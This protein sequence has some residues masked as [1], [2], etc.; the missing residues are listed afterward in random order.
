MSKPECQIC[1]RELPDTAYVCKPCT[2]RLDRILGEVT[3]LV[4]EVETT[5]L[6]QARTGSA[7]GVVNHK[8]D[9]DNLP[10]EAPAQA[11]R[12]L[13][14]LFR[15]L[16]SK[17]SSIRGVTRPVDDPSRQSGWLLNHTEWL[18]HREDGADIQRELE[19]AIHNLR[20][21][22]DLPPERVF[23][24]PCGAV[25]YTCTLIHD[26]EQEDCDE[27]PIPG[28]QPC[29]G[30][31]YGTPTS[32]TVR[33]NSCGSVQPMDDRREWLLKAVEDQLDYAARL[34]RAL[35]RLGMEVTGEAIRKWAE[36]GRLTAHSH[37]EN[38]RPLYRVGDVLD[39]LAL[40][41][42]RQSRKAAA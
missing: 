12:E 42:Q 28:S 34:S 33:C 31:L 13:R 23:A 19:W 4:G 6:R 40:E 32:K 35:S 22:I 36:R 37:D 26:H 17:V 11:L 41:A 18:R 9:F 25:D 39:L 29:T 10:V 3:A 20:K 24:G 30:D 14:D 38:N 1:A 2:Q 16:T 15:A 5:R 27:Q 8:F 21:T 7:T